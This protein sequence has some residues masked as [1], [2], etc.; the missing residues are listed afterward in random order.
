MNTNTY[1]LYKDPKTCFI[2]TCSKTDLKNPDLKFFTVRKELKQRWCQLV[3]RNC[4]NR[5]LFC[6]ADHLN[7]EEDLENYGQWI[8]GAK[9]RLKI[10]AILKN[11]S[12]KPLSAINK[13]IED[14]NR[15]STSSAADN[16]GMQID[17]AI[18]CDKRIGVSNK[19]VLAQP[20]T[21]T[22]ATQFRGRKIKES[23]MPSRMMQLPNTEKSPNQSPS[24]FGTSNFDS[25]SS[26]QQEDIEK[27]GREHL[28]KI[29]TNKPKMFLGLPKSFWWIIN[30]IAQECSCLAFHII[31]CLFKL[32]NNDSFARMS[33]EFQMA[34]STIRLVFEKNVVVLSTY[35]QN[36]IYLPPLSEIKK[37]LPLAFKIRY[38]NVQCIIDC[39]EIQIEKP[40]D[41][42]KQAQTWSQYKSCNT[43][44]YLIG[45]TPAGYISFISQ[46]YGGRTSDKAITENSGF[47]DVLPLNA[48][49]MADRGFKEIE[50]LKESHQNGKLLR[51]PSV[52]AN[53]KM[54]K[55]D[56]IKTKV[57]ASLRVHV[58]RVIRRLREFHMLK[59]HSVVNNKHLKYLDDLVIIACGLSNLQN[60]IIKDV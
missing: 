32:K 45:C 26:A 7:F 10:N 36:C 5:A 13:N 4:P 11:F 19:F 48:V 30:F 23:V 14:L 33:E 43:M 42:E 35:F 55:K 1:K 22:I 39:F 47:V 20:K 21:Q 24:L 41:P 3:G 18:Q 44:K 57:I 8:S 59:P 38:S 49:I 16:A 28:L 17:A 56:V 34:R 58:E 29:I 2:P 31:I 51:P 6:C 15:P 27:R 37:N 9:P 50:S 46:G 12:K 60:P 53:Q 54:T 25:S 52:F 40:S